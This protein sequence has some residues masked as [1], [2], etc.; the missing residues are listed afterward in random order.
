M[1]MQAA[2]LRNWLSFWPLAE[3]DKGTDR[4]VFAPEHEEGEVA[5]IAAS[6][7]GMHIACVRSL[8][9]E[10]IEGLD[11]PITV[12]G[13]TLI[14][15]L[16]SYG[17]QDEVTLRWTGKT[18]MVSDGKV[19][20]RIHP[21][22][23][24]EPW[25]P[26]QGVSDA[27]VSIDQRGLKE[28]LDI[29]ESTAATDLDKPILTGIHIQFIRKQGLILR[30]TNSYAATVCRHEVGNS[31]GEMNMVLIPKDLRLAMAE[32]GTMV[33]LF[34]YDQKLGVSDEYTY[35]E[36]S[37]LVGTYPPSFGRLAL[38]YD[39][40]FPIH[41]DMA[42]NLARAARNLDAPLATIALADH[43]VTLSLESA[44]GEYVQN[45]GQVGTGPDAPD[46]FSIQFPAQAMAAAIRGA[47]KGLVPVDIGEQ[48]LHLAGEDW[49]QWHMAIVSV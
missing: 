18:L 38:K 16:A 8:D 27:A 26:P 39:K 5:A 40:S 12:Q 3:H 4:L 23:S 22:D 7:R 47:G 6:F 1:K 11:G 36:M 44:K 28:K 17:A 42:A 29:L 20:T 2:A 49:H 14:G 48:T 43:Q 24:R 46:D 30:S 35:I 13:K 31:S 9:G 19:T 15:A 41:V 45:I 10:V 32:V 25:V 37:G 33:D 21:A 34:S